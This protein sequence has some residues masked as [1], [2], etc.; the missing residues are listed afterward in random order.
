M[1]IDR[2]RK[3]LYKRLI[4]IQDEKL[5][6]CLALLEKISEL[7]IRYKSELPYEFK[8]KYCDYAEPFMLKYRALLGEEGS[9]GDEEETEE[10]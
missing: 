9:Y 6:L 8:E 4:Q 1:S 10:N 7:F 5:D 3:E 2:T